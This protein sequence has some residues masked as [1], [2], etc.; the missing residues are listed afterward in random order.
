MSSSWKS[1]IT[2][3]RRLTKDNGRHAYRCA[4]I[5]R[6]LLADKE[7]MDVECGHKPDEADAR[8]DDIADRFNFSSYEL[9]QMLDHFP[10]ADDWQTGKLRSLY[11]RMCREA[12][13]EQTRANKER[14][15]QRREEASQQPPTTAAPNNTKPSTQATVSVSAHERTSPLPVTKGEPK[16]YTEAVEVIERLREQ[17]QHL[18]CNSVPRER[19]ESLRSRYS[20]LEAKYKALQRDHARLK[21]TVAK[22]KR[23][24]QA[25]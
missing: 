14:A 25:V 8:L 17:G 2:E 5:C 1:L 6:T 9:R 12:N 13:A 20:D 7:F 23:N 22:M 4:E 15:Q 21:A 3:A 16:D 11:N 18:Q 24:L 10:N 19:Y